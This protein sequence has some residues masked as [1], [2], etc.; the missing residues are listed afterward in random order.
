VKA[1]PVAQVFI[2]A[3]NRDDMFG[4]T[5][6]GHVIALFT[7]TSSIRC[8]K[9]DTRTDDEIDNEI[10]SYLQRKDID[11]WELRKTLQTIHVSELPLHSAPLHSHPLLSPA[12]IH[13]SYPSPLQ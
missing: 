1:T 6:K 12:N 13:P 11:S 10:I 5:N 8:S 9:V 4:L 3:V 2:T 7:A